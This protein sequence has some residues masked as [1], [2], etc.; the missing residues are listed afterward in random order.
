MENNLFAESP[1]IY[2]QLHT[3]AKQTLAAWAESLVDWYL[4]K[5]TGKNKQQREWEQWLEVTVVRQA[6]TVEN[7]FMNFKYILELDPNKVWDYSEP[8]GWIP[9]K[10][11]KEYEFPN[12]PL[13]Q[14]T[15]INW[16]R[17]YKD[18]WDGRFHLNDMMGGDHVFA[19]T[20]N[21]RDALMISL[22]F[23]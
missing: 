4:T 22:R 1:G 15:V 10:E 11:F 12:R 8:F 7:Y 23:S 21:E 5:R 6:S 2:R 16:F 17:G 20:N 13:G 14:N 3:Q 18:Q 19:A 9:V